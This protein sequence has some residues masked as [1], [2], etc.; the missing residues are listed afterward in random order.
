MRLS[1]DPYRIDLG[2]DRRAAA[3][4]EH[5]VLGDIS[6]HDG[7]G[8]HD[9]CP[10]QAYRPHPEADQNLSCP[11]AG[12]RGMTQREAMQRVLKR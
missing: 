1:D 8:F 3:R 11:Q 2:I 7:H 6:R 12:V 4:P 5:P 10:E 9:G